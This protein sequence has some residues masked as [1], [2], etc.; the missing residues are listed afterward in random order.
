MHTRQS[1]SRAIP[2]RSR[3]PRPTRSARSARR[4]AWW[5]PSSTLAGRSIG[6]RSSPASVSPTDDCSTRSSRRPASPCTD[7]RPARSPSRSP[8][9][10]LL[11]A[12]SLADDQFGRATVVGLMSSAP[13]RFNGARVS[14]ARWARTARRAGVVRGPEQWTHRL[15]RRVADDNDAAPLIEFVAWLV[16]EC[17]VDERA[18]WVDWADWARRFLHSILGSAAARRRWPEAEARGVRRGRAR[19]RRSAPH[20]RGR[21]G[22][23]D[24]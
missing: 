3:S 21:A 16:D 11:A 14:A 1:A 12:L 22:R 23:G 2:R 15:E 10:R 9:A 20:R 8:A 7:H 17:G 13:L 6:S 4:C 18:S 19:S 5:P 24:S